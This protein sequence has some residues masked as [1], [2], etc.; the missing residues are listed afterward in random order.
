M[1]KILIIVLFTSSIYAKNNEYSNSDKRKVR[2][3]IKMSQKQIEKD[4]Q[5]AHRIFAEKCFPLLSPQGKQKINNKINEINYLKITEKFES[6]LNYAFNCES[7]NK[8]NDKCSDW[9]NTIE[10]EYEELDI[11]SYLKTIFEATISKIK[12]CAEMKNKL[13]EA[14]DLYLASIHCG[15]MSCSTNDINTYASLLNDDLT[16][17]EEIGQ[18]VPSTILFEDAS[19]NEKDKATI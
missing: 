12:K 10:T 5:K 6:S 15:N 18:D 16:E 9:K 17:I 11:S 13:S 14:K 19:N 7:I 4:Y 1:N 8:G 2:N 3:K